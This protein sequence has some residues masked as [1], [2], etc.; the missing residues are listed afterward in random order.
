M[1]TAVSLRESIL[2]GRA[3]AAGYALLRRSLAKKVKAPPRGRSTRQTVVE[4]CVVFGYDV[5]SREYKK[6]VLNITIPE[7]LI[8]ALPKAIAF[9]LFSKVSYC[10]EVFVFTL[11]GKQISLIIFVNFKE[12]L[13]VKISLKAYLKSHGKEQH[14]RQI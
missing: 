13:R 4:N 12:K 9:M 1:L 3:A 14:D 2:Q 10:P 11:Y 5:I 6:K 7:L 8:K